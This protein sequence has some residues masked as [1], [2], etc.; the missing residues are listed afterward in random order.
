MRSTLISVLLLT[1]PSPA[2]SFV[3]GPFGPSTPRKSGAVATSASCTGGT[4][5]HAPSG[6]TFRAGEEAG[7]REPPVI[8]V[9][10]YATEDGGVVLPRCPQP[11]ATIRV[12]VLL[13]DWADYDPR[14]DLSNPNNPGSGGNPDYQP[15]TPQALADFLNGTGGVREYFDDVSHGAVDLEFHVYG[16]LRS[17]TPG[18]FLGPRS[19]YFTVF[20]DRTYC[21]HNAVMRDALRDAVVQ[22]GVDF[23]EFDRIGGR[24]PGW[25]PNVVLVYEGQAGLCSGTNFSWLDGGASPAL[26]GQPAQFYAPDLR[27]LVPGTD[28]QAAHF[29]DQHV[30][31]NNFNNIPEQRYGGDLV[32]TSTWAHELGHALFGFSDYYEPK[33]RLRPW[34][35]STGS[36]T[37]A[38]SPHPAAWEKW[39]FMR[40]LEPDAITSDGRYRLDANEKPDGG[41]YETGTFLHVIPLNAAGTRYLTI[42]NRW[43][44]ADGNTGTR[45][46]QSE[47]RESGLTL[48]LFDWE[49]LHWDALPQVKRQVPA[50]AEGDEWQASLAAFRPGDRI[51]ICDE[52]G[53]CLTID[54]IGAPGA[55]VGFRVS[56]FGRIFANAFEAVPD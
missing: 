8:S 19:S 18:A 17:D 30:I 10:G 11:S 2:W 3:E 21:D 1:L 22:A 15:T 28:P 34:G 46:A 55:E 48:A 5:G 50:R 36:S 33:F 29:A 35:L 32:E 44:D 40:W 7:L 41:G 13:V 39:L 45:W 37:T 26:G 49:R 56:G 4:W 16:W 31:V 47:G 6:A 25:I 27:A 43:F 38:A 23:R 20:D 51:E 9:Y 14:V 52:D 12:P 24:D 53:R 42:E 54:E